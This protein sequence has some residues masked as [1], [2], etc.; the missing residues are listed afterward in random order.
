MTD[1]RNAYIEKTTENLDLLKA[2]I[3]K[4]EALANKKTGEARRDL[5]ERLDDIRQTREKA[6]ERLKELQR[7]TSPA[8]DDIKQGFED[9][10]QSLSTAVDSATDRFQ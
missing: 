2:K 10:W 7:A 1:N 8:W 6:E 4:L 9:A 3:R 5:R